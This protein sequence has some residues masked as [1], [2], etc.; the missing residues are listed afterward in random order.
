[1]KF[2]FSMDGRYLSIILCAFESRFMNVVSVM[3][4]VL[5][6]EAELW[7][8]GF[9]RWEGGL[10]WSCLKRVCEYGRMA[11]LEFSCR[12]IGVRKYNV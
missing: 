9:G 1:M 2:S 5:A 8:C 6:I 11:G 12:E 4:R 7:R 3:F 10:G